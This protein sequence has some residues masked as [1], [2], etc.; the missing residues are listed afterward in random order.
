M[1]QSERET[2]RQERER[3]REK[4]RERE[5]ERERREISHLYSDLVSQRT[6]F[7]GEEKKPCQILGFGKREKKKKR[8]DKGQMK[9]KDFSFLR[10]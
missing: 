8:Q 3:E 10:V 4:E 7:S 2:N 6:F 9:A 5:R 1:E